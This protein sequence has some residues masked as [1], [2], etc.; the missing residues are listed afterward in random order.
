MGNTIRRTPVSFDIPDSPDYEF[1]NITDFKGINISDNPFT[2]NSNTASDMLNLYV[3]ETNTLTTRPRLEMFQSFKNARPNMSEFLM[4]VP[5]S[6]GYMINYKINSSSYATDLVCESNDELIYITVSNGNLIKGPNLIVF[7]QSDNIYVLGNNSYCVITYTLT[8]DIVSSATCS[9]VKGYVP[10]LSVGGTNLISG[11][12]YESL[13]ILT[14]KY[15]QTYF[16]DGTWNPEDLKKKDDDEINNKYISHNYYNFLSNVK[17]FRILESPTEF[18]GSTVTQ[19]KLLFGRGEG[20]NSLYLY[21]FKNLTQTQIGYPSASELPEY[22]DEVYG[23]CSSN[24]EIIVYYY[25]S[26]VVGNSSI[27]G[28]LYVKRNNEWKTICRDVGYDFDKLQFDDV[29]SKVVSMSSDGNIIACLVDKGLSNPYLLVYKYDETEDY[30]KIL[31]YSLSSEINDYVIFLSR[32]GN[33]LAV[34]P[35]ARSSNGNVYIFKNLLSQENITEPTYTLNIA[36]YP[37]QT[38]LSNNGQYFITGSYSDAHLYDLN[39]STDNTPSEI[40]ISDKNK[41]VLFSSQNL[42]FSPDNNKL[43]IITN[44]GTDDIYE[45]YLLLNEYDEVL[46]EYVSIEGLRYVQCDLSGASSYVA[47][48]YVTNNTIVYTD[49]L[50]NQIQSI[51]FDFNSEL[52][53]LEI[54]RTVSSDDDDYNTWSELNSLIMKSI[55]S[56]RFDNERWFA[57]RNTVFKTTNNDPTYIEVA[58]YSELGETDETITGFN[59]V[60]N[61]MLIAYKDNYIW[62]ITPTTITEND[63]SIKTYVYQES[64]NTV[65]NN[66]VGASLVTTYTEIPLQIAYDGIYGLKQLTNI[67]A[68]DRIS[69]SL[70][71]PIAKK[72]L[73]EDKNVIRNAKT[74]NRLYWTYIILSYEKITKV[75]LLDNRTT[76]WYYWEF[77]IKVNDAFV[78]NNIVYFSNPDGMLYTLQTSDII[79]KYNPDTTEYYDDGQQI[80]NWFWKSQILPLGTINYSK[81]LIDTTF[82]FTDTDTTDEYSLNYRF[83]AYRKVVSQ[84]NTTT[85]SN[86]LNYIQ[87]T[88]KKTLINRCNFIQLELS[89]TVDDLNNN[90]LRLVGLGFKYVL[91]EGLL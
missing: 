51:Y 91:L 36:S 10:T 56:I 78:K 16:W 45:G 49:S 82:I 84:T 33:T 12:S 75:Y 48:A 7:E 6:F 23:D 15:K 55:C 67:S 70:S 77:P 4:C 35:R 62:A 44:Q 85:I 57:A 34:L 32:N 53:L 14:D 64:K 47:S 28:G 46:D 29:Y 17:S 54:V 72:W 83:T 88:T 1:L 69:E 61:D 87:S 66:A 79:N 71:D 25:Y 2:L 5:L 13:N 8:N 73:D 22:M 40:E 41:S 39:V 26:S 27:D 81:R 38:A 74:L 68:V 20:Y 19:T 89:N 21:D 3:D 80:I 50:G 11:T 59:L 24:G 30:D 52:P 42:L 18:T 63:V 43:Y 65:G 76:E 60:Q 90:K 58:N 9:E 37:A 86:R 31:E